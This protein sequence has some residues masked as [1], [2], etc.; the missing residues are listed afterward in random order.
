M[1]NLARFRSRGFELGFFSQLTVYFA[2]GSEDGEAGV[3]T[4]FARRWRGEGCAGGAIENLC[5][6]PSHGW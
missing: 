3:P 1:I 4:R 2:L 5:G 6:G